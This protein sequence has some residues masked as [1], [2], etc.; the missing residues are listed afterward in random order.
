MYDVTL[1]KWVTSPKFSI[2]FFLNFLKDNQLA[3][4]KTKPYKKSVIVT[5][6]CSLM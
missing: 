1:N 5:L 2:A 4:K 6:A 3:N